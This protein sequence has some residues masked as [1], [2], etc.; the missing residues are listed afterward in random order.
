MAFGIIDGHAHIF[1][2]LAGACGLPDVATHLLHQQRAMHEHGNQPYRRLRDNAVVTERGLWAAEDSSVAGRREVGFRVGRCGRFEWEVAGE[3]QYVQFLPPTMADMSAPADVVTRQM[4][5]AGIATAVLQ[6]DHIYGDSAEDFADA[7]ARYPGRFIGLAQVQE[8]WAWRD[9]QIIR[10]IDQVERLGMA[11]LYFTYSGLFRNG[12]RMRPSDPTYDPLWREVT[13][14]DLPVF[15]VNRDNSPV[16]SY[17]DELADVA[18]ILQRHPTIRSVLVH[19]LPTSRYADAN[20][21]LTLPPL[22]ERLM[23]ELPVSAEL[24]YPIS[25]GGRFEYPYP[26]ALVHFQQL[27]DRFGPR[28]F[29]WGSDMPNVERYC[30]YRQTFTYVWNHADFLNDAD[31]RAIFR[32][33]ALALFRRD[34]IAGTG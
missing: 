15:W 3:A 11:G 5:Y 23:T 4:D 13:R 25:W 28:R 18:R 19:G 24:L 30:T 7:M 1:P 21:R 8:A 14:L 17:E 27:L 20:E 2:P 16:G 6:N 10:L 29:V 12:Y 26:K 33:N 22:I 32:D 31:R 34:R 9:D